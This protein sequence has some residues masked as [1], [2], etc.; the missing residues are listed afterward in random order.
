MDRLYPFPIAETLHYFDYAATALIP[1]PVIDAWTNYQNTIGVGLDRGRS[2]LSAAA[3]SARDDALRRLSRFFSLAEDRAWLFGKNVTEAINLVALG[4]EHM[5]RP[6][7]YIVVGPFEHHSNFLPWRYLAKRAGAV[8]MELPIGPDG[9]IDLD[10]LELISPHIKVFAYSSVSNINGYVLD[11][12]PIL[13]RLPQCAVV[14]CDVSQEAGHRR[15]Q[16]PPRV[17]VQFLPSHKM[18]GPKGIAAAVFPN[19]ML[20]YVQ[21]VLLGGGMVNSVGLDDTWA[22]GD[23]KYAAGTMDVGL[24][25]AWAAAADFLREID[26]EVIETFEHTQSRKIRDGLRALE[27]VELLLP[28]NPSDSI[29]TFT[30]EGRHPHDIEYYLSNQDIIIRTGHLC[31]QN[32]IRKLEVD[33][34][35]RISLGLGVSDRNIDTLL[36]AMEDICK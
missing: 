36:N 12:V 6:M 23:R 29:L 24:L 19:G 1:Q 18:Y 33:A 13:N 35:N 20:G 34:V 14:C 21:P 2:R 3:G 22:D 32:S 10:Y 11:V 8:F 25:C 7:D 30:I 5:I 28:Q 15:V 9:D 16:V 26:F 31:T 17:D 27:K 4:L